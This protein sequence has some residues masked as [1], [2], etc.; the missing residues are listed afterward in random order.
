M[1]RCSHWPAAFRWRRAARG[2]TNRWPLRLDVLFPIGRLDYIFAG[3]RSRTSCAGAKRCRDA[4]G[5]DHLPLL[6]TLKY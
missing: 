5:S 4:R 3:R 2:R 1:A 6:M